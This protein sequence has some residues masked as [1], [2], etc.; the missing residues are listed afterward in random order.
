M[1]RELSFEAALLAL[2]S[3]PFA[4]AATAGVFEQK[5]GARSIPCCARHL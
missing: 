2:L 4:N 3:F 5:R 1:P